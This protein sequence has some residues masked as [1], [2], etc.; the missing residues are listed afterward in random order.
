VNHARPFEQTAIYVSLGTFKNIGCAN[1]HYGIGNVWIS[2]AYLTL[3]Y[4]CC[5]TAR[6]IYTQFSPP[7]QQVMG[8]VIRVDGWVITYV[9]VHH[10]PA[11]LVWRKVARFVYVL[12]S[13]V[14]VNSG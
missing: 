7:F 10:P 5:F 8:C 11:T 14:R 3:A 2:G 9:L 12:V 1:I 6:F 4:I 13:A